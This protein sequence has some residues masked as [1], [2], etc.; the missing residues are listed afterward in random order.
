MVWYFIGVYIINRTLHGRLEIWNFSSS[1]EKYF[2][3]ERSDFFQHE[4]RNFIYLH[5]AIW[6]P[7]FIFCFPRRQAL[8]VMKKQTKKIHVGILLRIVMVS[9]GTNLVKSHESQL[10]KVWNWK[11]LGL[12]VTRQLI[13]GQTP[14]LCITV[15]WMWPHWDNNSNVVNSNTE[16]R[17]LF[18]WQVDK[19]DVKLERKIQ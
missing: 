16:K 4:K 14:K 19:V 11:C 5:A 1:V 12:Y 15:Y 17:L 7:L 18:Y 9:P 6:Y 2:T 8:V 10:K 3:S 13:W